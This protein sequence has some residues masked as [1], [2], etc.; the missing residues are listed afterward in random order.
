MNKIKNTLKFNNSILN[1]E[2]RIYCFINMFKKKVFSVSKYFSY[3]KYFFPEVSFL[4]NKLA[5]EKEIQIFTNLAKTIKIEDLQEF[6]YL[7]EIFIFKSFDNENSF[8]I[9]NLNEKSILRIAP[10]PNSPP[11]IGNLRMILIH[12]YYQDKYN[13]KVNLRFDDTDPDNKPPTI[14]G[15]AG[16][17][18]ACA[19]ANLKLENIFA[20]SLNIKRYLQVIEKGLSSGYFYC[21]SDKLNKYEGVSNSIQENLRIWNERYSYNNFGLRIKSTLAPKHLENWA[22]FRFVKSKH[23]IKSH[24]GFPLLNFQGVIDDFFLGTTHILRGSDLESNEIRGRELWNMLNQIYNEKRLFPITKYWGKIKFLDG[25]SKS[26]KIVEFYADKQISLNNLV[27]DF[28]AIK[29]FNLNY[30]GFYDYFKKNGFSKNDHSLDIVKLKNL[31]LRSN[32]FLEELLVDNENEEYDVL[33]ENRKK[34]C[35]KILFPKNLK[36]GLYKVKNSY[37]LFNMFLDKFYII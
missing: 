22:I 30:E 33:W 2:F 16:Y 37:F 21:N 1:L 26:S 32:H 35:K 11:H 25:F 7:E 9:E 12:K 5:L 10:N 31:I 28:R 23:I 3:I 24:L 19:W 29:S 27:L 36:S 4:E 6:K 34:L 20:A 18:D 17:L 15:Y 14:L 13:L 8:K